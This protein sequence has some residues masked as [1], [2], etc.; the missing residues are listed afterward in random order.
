[1]LVPLMLFWY[2]GLVG[3]PD[4]PPLLWEMTFG[5]RVTFCGT[6]AG[7]IARCAAAKTKRLLCP[8]GKE[9]RKGGLGRV[10]QFHLN[11][12]DKR[13]IKRSSPAPGILDNLLGNAVRSRAAKSHREIA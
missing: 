8:R 10:G 11:L 4:S 7:Q 9:W 2:I 5:R 1:M 3:S 6:R 12:L 13:S